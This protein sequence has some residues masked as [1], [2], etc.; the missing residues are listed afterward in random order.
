VSGNFLFILGVFIVEGVGLYTGVLTA[1]VS[2]F[3]FVVTG[4][5]VSLCL[6]E[7]AHA[8]AALRGGDRSVETRGYLSL[9]PLAY[10]HPVLSIVLP[11]LYLLIGGIGLPGGAVYIDHNALK[12]RHWDSFVSAA[13]P[14]ANLVFLL[15]LCLPFAFDWIDLAPE[16]STVMFWPAIAYLA[17]LQASVLVLNLL[18]IPGLDGFGIIQPYLPHE[19]QAQASRIAPMVSGLLLMLFL[20]GNVTSAIWNAVDSLTT[21]LGIDSDFVSYGAELFTFWE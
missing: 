8:F 13:G 10:A 6:H 2:V 11:L 4:W 17:A 21:V 19:M 9:D 18:P 7:G 15:A 16:E 5:I 12:G 14:L 1:K 20:N 3:A